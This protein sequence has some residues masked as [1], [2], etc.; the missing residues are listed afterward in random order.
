MTDSIS[1][2]DVDPTNETAFTC[3]SK[4]I[5]EMRVVM[6]K[7]IGYIVVP[8]NLELSDDVSLKVAE[9]L[10]DLT[11]KGDKDVSC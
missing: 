11:K 7:G 10:V 5:R 4:C 2:Y 9:L 3:I 8:K 6:V 1:L